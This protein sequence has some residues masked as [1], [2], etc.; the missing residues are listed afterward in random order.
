[1]SDIFENV[2]PMVHKS[3]ISV[4][5]HWWAGD[6]ASR[7]FIALRDEQ[8]ILGTRCS[9]CRKTFVPPRKTC[10][11][12]FTPNEDWVEIS[13]QGTLITHTIVRRHLASL[14]KKPPVMYGL[15]KLEGADTAFLHILDE[16][17]PED[18]KIGMKVEA[19]FA[20]ERKGTIFDIE[21]FKPVK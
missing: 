16:I 11:V 20:S 9:H 4:P 21:Y 13:P 18:V 12:C 19:K 15:I 6:T 7:F 2:E 8:K 3:R 1:M 17:R 10:P 14:P 5:Y